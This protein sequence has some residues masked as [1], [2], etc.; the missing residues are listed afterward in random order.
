MNYRVR[1]FIVFVIVVSI[2]LIANYTYRP[3]VYS[4]NLQDYGLADTIGSL[5]CVIGASFSGLS[6]KVSSKSELRSIKIAIIVMYI[7]EFVQ[8][9]PT[10]GT[11]DWKDLVAITISSIITLWIYSKIGKEREKLKIYL[12]K[13]LKNWTIVSSYNNKI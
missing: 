6:F 7:L 4:N 3:Y 9:P 2:G 10:W 12:A 8:L 5:V 1:Y 11:F 13:L